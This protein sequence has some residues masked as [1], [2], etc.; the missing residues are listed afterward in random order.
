MKLE[1]SSR[2]DRHSG[3]AGAAF[4]A[5]ML[6]NQSWPT[7]AYG[8]RSRPG[9]RCSGPAL[10]VHARH[11]LD[12]ASVGFPPAGERRFPANALAQLPHGQSLDHGGRTNPTS[13]TRRPPVLTRTNLARGIDP[14]TRLGVRPR[15]DPGLTPGSQARPI[16]TRG[17]VSPPGSSAT[18][19]TGSSS[20]QLGIE[21]LLGAR[22]SGRSV[23]LEGTGVEGSAEARHSP[24]FCATRRTESGGLRPDQKGE[25]EWPQGCW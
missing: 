5:S 16:D 3:I 8:A 19:R 2:T 23:S 21:W 14:G 9:Q 17:T 11:L 25:T 18:T 1:A 20:R 15:I 10:T 4:A 7:P 24:T 6:S 12:Q 13:G 22:W